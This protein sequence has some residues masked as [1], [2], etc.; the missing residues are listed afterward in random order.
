MVVRQHSF[1]KSLSYSVGKIG[2]FLVYIFIQRKVGAI[3]AD[4]ES[5]FALFIFFLL[6]QFVQQFYLNSGICI[7]FNCNAFLINAWQIL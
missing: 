7:E 2:G 1:K 3:E 6:F 5:L 4:C